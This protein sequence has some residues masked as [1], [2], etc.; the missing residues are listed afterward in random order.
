MTNSTMK[1]KYV[2]LIERKEI[3]GEKKEGSKEK[4]KGRK[5]IEKLS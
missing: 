5:S 4:M 3:K 2:Y 1:S